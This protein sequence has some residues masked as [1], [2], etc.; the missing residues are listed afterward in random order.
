MKIV[1]LNANQFDRYTSNHKYRN[2]YQ[3]SAY[4]NT[5]K[6][7]GYNIHYLG[8]VDERNS[9]IG[10]TLIM[11]KTI[12]MS[13]KIAYAPHG[14]LFDY[15]DKIETKKMA[16]KLKQLL[17][18]QGF[19]LLRMDPYIPISVRNNEGAIINLNRQE[20]EILKNLKEA[21]FKY[22][23]KNLYFENEKPRWEALVL[24][25]KDQQSLFDS[26]DKRTRNKI[27]KAAATGIEIS[28]DPNNDVTDLYE[29][30]KRKEKYPIKYYEQLCQNYGNNINIYYAKINTETF[31]I[32]SRETYEREMQNNEQLSEQIQSSNQDA[33][34][35]DLILNK[36]IESDKLLEV[37]KNN[38][39][40]ATELIKS[41]PNGIPIGGAIVI[42]YDNAA[43]ILCEGIDEKYSSL[44][45][46]YLLKWQLI[47]NCLSKGYKYVNLGGIV[48]EFEKENKY[49]GLNEM[50]LG[51]NSLVTEYIGEFDII[52]NNF[53]YNLYKSFN[54]GE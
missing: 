30:I 7:F 2:F 39:L 19:M 17:N 21:S 52:L 50:K 18:K 12:F 15:D 22:K 28:I 40:T 34:D 38:M 35:N 14:I 20:E 9:L 51:F 27:R 37:Y 4:A 32:N 13:Y 29:F 6:K 36:K 47:C 43:F 5:M 25:N 41:Y 3:T 46:N 54:K 11:Y 26:F 42:N 33:I 1:T 23:G 16:E 45:A 49:S 31:I 10:A 8:F 48:G 24:L 53:A 44:N